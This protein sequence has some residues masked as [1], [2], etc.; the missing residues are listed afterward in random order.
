MSLL[1]AQKAFYRPQQLVFY[2]GNL[3]AGTHKVSVQT[4][5]D[6]GYLSIDYA[7]VYTSLSLG[8]R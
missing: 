8:G 2:A 3:S 5:S 1:S 4:K 6:V 7:N